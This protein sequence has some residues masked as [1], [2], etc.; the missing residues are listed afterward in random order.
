MALLPAHDPAPAARARALAGLRVHGR[1]RARVLPACASATTARS[2][3]PT[4]STRST[5]P[6]TTCAGSRATSTSCRW[7]RATSPRSAGA[8]T[9]PTT[10][11]PTASSSRTSSSPTRSTTCDRAVFFRYMVESLA[12]ERGMIAT[13]MPKPFSHLTGNGCHFHMSLWRD[14]ENVFEVDPADDPRGMGLSETRL[15]VHRRAE[16]ARE[17]VHR[18][19]RA[20]GD[21]LQA[22][23]GRARR[24]GATLGAGV[25]ELRLQQPHADAAHPG[26]G[27]RSR[28]GPWT[29]RATP[30]WPPA[31]MLAA[32]LD[33][34]EHGLDPGEPTT[35]LNLHEL[36]EAE[37]AELGVELLPAN[38]L[39]ATRELERRRR[40][41]CRAGHDRARGLHRLLRAGQAARVPGVRTTR[42]RS[43]SSTATC[44]CSRRPPPARG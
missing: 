37:R 3:W 32:G 17:G 19:D 7:W 11:T 1:R 39:D 20:D 21:V 25:R 24:S 29:A 42:S 28:T 6:V 10:R 4:R 44:S 34:I 41:A 30:T 2:S 33:G 35:E 9:R 16:G 40:A 5:S 36:T 26:P 27:P 31:V 15:P 43:G 18:G 12:Q 14:G 8:T 23:G 22:A 38:L 13:F